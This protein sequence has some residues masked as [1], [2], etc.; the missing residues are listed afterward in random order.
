MFLASHIIYEETEA[1]RLCYLN[2]WLVTKPDAGLD[3]VE[4]KKGTLAVARSSARGTHC[5]EKG[6]LLYCKCHNRGTSKLG[7]HK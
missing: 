1:Q 4:K 7:L 2:S 5:S 6:T 3:A